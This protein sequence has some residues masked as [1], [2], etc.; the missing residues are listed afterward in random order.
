MSIKYRPE[1]DGLRAIAIILVVLFHYVNFRGGFIGVDVFFVI[2]GYLIT[3]IITE[4]LEE[5]RFTM[6]DFY[7]R[8]IKRI[9]PTL[10]T[11]LLSCLIFGWFSLLATEYKSLVLHISTGTIFLSN[12]LLLNEIGY[13]DT[14]SES[15]PLLHLWSLSIEEQFYII[16]PALI[17]MCYKFKIPI[18]PVIISILILSFA[19]NISILRTVYAAITP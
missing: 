10:I 3:S 9:F 17:M 16:W 13:F 7:K 14:I 5:N 4:Q 2:S 8:R 12:F 19:Y 18:R 15:K 11:I 6:L 1:I